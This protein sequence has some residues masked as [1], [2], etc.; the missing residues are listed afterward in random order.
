MHE[1]KTID[2]KSKLE[3]PEKILEKLEPGMTVFLSTGV[4]EPR[5]LLKKLICT[6]H[7]N[8]SDLELIQIFSVGEAISSKE[9]KSQ[10]YRLK[11]FFPGWI[12][13]E[14]VTAGS[15]D[16]IPGFF[17]SGSTFDRIRTDYH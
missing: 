16:L 4:A 9:I 6:D 11:T 8:I 12:A 7:Y 17:L 1:E 3:K 13:N 5:T 15:V 2:W 14:A 10:K